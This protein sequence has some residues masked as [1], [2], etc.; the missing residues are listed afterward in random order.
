MPT[1]GPKQARALLFLVNPGRRWAGWPA[2]LR[3]GAVL[4]LFAAGLSAEEI[5]QLRASNITIGHGR[6]QVSILRH[7]EDWSVR[8]SPTLSGRLLEWLTD[9]RLWATNELVIEGPEGPLNNEE[10]HQILFRYRHR[11]K[12]RRSKRVARPHSS[13]QGDQQQMSETGKDNEN[14]P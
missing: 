3:D 13:G 2:G 12:G 10:V 7:D 5:S 14:G 6:L 11:I 4:A 8:L 9:R 1:F